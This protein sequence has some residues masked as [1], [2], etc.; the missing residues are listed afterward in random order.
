MFS[1]IS[2]AVVT[3]IITVSTAA[4]ALPP[5][6]SPQC[7]SSVVLSNSD[8]ALVAAETISL[9][10]GSI[11]P[12]AMFDVGLGCTPPVTGNNC[13]GTF[14]AVI[15]DPPETDW[16]GLMAINCISGTL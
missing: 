9:H 6:T 12:G 4:V 3:V 7:C 13:G 2:V 15:C 16:G 5:P 10:I 11:Y 8:A 1:K 14:K